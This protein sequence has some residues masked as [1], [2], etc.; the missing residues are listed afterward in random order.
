[1]GSRGLRI[2]QLL[3]KNVEVSP[4][5][6]IREDSPKPGKFINFLSL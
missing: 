4:E 6:P 5:S 2:L 1:M 3:K